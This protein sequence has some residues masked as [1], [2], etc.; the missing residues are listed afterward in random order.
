MF[1]L[2]MPLLVLPAGALLSGCCCCNLGDWIPDNVEDAMLEEA[3]ER[4]VEAATGT[5]IDAE[6]GRVEF[7][8][9]DGEKLVMGEGHAGVDPRIPVIG[10]PGCPVAGGLAA[11]ANGEFN[12]TMVQGD[13]DVAYEDLE[14]HYLKQL[15]ALGAKPQQMVQSTGGGNR[16]KVFQA[17]DGERFK[18]LSIVIAEEENGKTSAMVNVV[19]DTE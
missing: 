9:K 19:V 11:E 18:T 15:E 10:H 14:A 2:L 4:G 8:G 16:G 3:V 12:G 1:R 13:C 6:D 7:Q 17:T 5:K